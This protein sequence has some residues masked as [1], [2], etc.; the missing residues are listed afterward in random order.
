M[1]R[2]LLVVAMLSLAA[3]LAAQKRNEVFAFFDDLSVS[4]TEAQGTK[5]STGYGFALRHYSSPRISTELSIAR[6]YQYGAYFTPVDANENAAPPEQF[7]AR[8]LPV[9]LISSYHF[10][11]D[12]RWQPYLGLG[13]HHVFTLDGPGLDSQT[14]FELAGGVVFSVTDHFFVRADAKRLLGGSSLRYDPSSRGA[15]GF[16]W[17][18]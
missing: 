1:K 11:P 15:L 10:A 18:F 9:D 4:S 7:R 6:H 5:L 12:S 2:L 13:L 8:V 3:P 17:R 14:R 16:S